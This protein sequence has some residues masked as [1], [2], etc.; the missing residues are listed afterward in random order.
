MLNQTLYTPA[1][2]ALAALGFDAIPLPEYPRPQ[3]RRD[4]YLCLNGAWDFR[5]GGGEAETILVPYPP[6]SALSGICRAIPRDAT[7]HYRR[8]VTL[9][10]DFARPGQR[11]LLHFGAVDQIAEVT[12]NGLAV[13]SHTGG[14]DAF[15]FDV[16][17]YLHAGENILDVL[18]RDPLDL[19]LPY[20]KQSARRGGMWYTPVS[21]IWQTVW[22]EAV[23]ERHV[24]SLRITPTCTAVTVEAE[25]VETGE[26]T[27]TL[28]DGSTLTA[29]LTAGKA[30]LTPPDPHPWS[31]E[32][33]TLYPFTLRAEGDTVESYFALRTLTTE[34]VDGIPRLCL[35]GKPYFFNGLLDQGYF[36]DGIY[37]PAAYS[38]FEDDIRAMKA[39]GFNTLRK[40]IKIEPAAFYYACD[41][42]GMVVFQ[43]MVNNSD[44]RF[45]RDTALPTVGIKRLPDRLLHRSKASRDAFYAGMHRTV[46]RL[47]SYPCICYWTIFN[48]GWGQFDHRAAYA[49]LKAL[50]RTRFIDSVSGW[51]KPLF[52]EAASD[53]ESH[54]VYFKPY[55]FKPAKK[56]VVLS[57]FGGYA[58]A[59]DGHRFNPE[60]VYGYRTYDTCAALAEGIAALYRDEIMPAIPRGLCAAIYTQVSDVEDETNG[61]L[62]YDRRVNKLAGRR[63][64]D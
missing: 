31:P 61:I 49:K 4:S 19:T 8:A 48:E 32:S 54:H 50:D 55:R 47:Y 35:N 5:V 42:L 7:M 38:C 40:H 36:S 33:P 1:G 23:P 30:T 34:T 3:L 41:R 59:L 20:G 17:E 18:V 10:D 44:Y 57:E 16:T 26:I 45:F 27:V 39:L 9:P 29:P 60:K 6:E 28:P 12:L 46:A 56:P 62:T 14:Y 13:G 52:G 25:G 51:F 43:D 58:C 37:T 11:V 63:V 22:M 21:G 24:H 15:S 64:M 2:E 53:V